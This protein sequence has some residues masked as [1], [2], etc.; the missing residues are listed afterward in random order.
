MI[1]QRLALIL[2]ISLLSSCSESL[3]YDMY[4]QHP[5]RLK[6]ALA[7]CESLSSS[8]KNQTL[9]CDVVYSA[10][11]DFAHLLIEQQQDPQAFGKRIL[12]AQ[13]EIDH[14]KNKAAYQAK[15]LEIAIMLAVI[16]ESSSDF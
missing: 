3:S 5:D 10:T 2:T 1:R 15:A 12:V 4:M 13:E 7:S 6:K 9:E 16:R 8:S 14:L 11:R